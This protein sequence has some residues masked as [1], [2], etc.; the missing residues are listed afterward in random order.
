MSHRLT[1]LHCSLIVAGQVIRMHGA[2]LRVLRT[3]TY[4]AE[5]PMVV[6]AHRH[7][8]AQGPVE[9]VFRAEVIEIRQPNEQP[10]TYHNEWTTGCSTRLA[11]YTVE[12]RETD[13]AWLADG[14]ESCKHCGDV[15]RRDSSC[16][17]QLAWAEGDVADRLAALGEC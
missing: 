13:A 15:K 17:C 2:R 5:P 6:V 12:L 7:V 16:E 10:Q 14:L 4:D 9:S 1:Q 8:R 11:T 3:W